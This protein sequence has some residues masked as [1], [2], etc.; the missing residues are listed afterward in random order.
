MQEMAQSIQSEA[1]SAFTINESMMNSMKIAHETMEISKGV[2]DN[3]SQICERFDEGWNKIERIRDQ[4][5][6]ISSSINTANKTVAE[7]QSSMQT[8]NNLLKGIKEIADQTNLL[9]LNATIESARAGEHGKG[10][11][12]VASEVRKLAEKSSTIVGDISQVTTG[13]FH[14]SQEAYE[15]VNEGKLATNEGQ[16]LIVNIFSYF[17]YLKDSFDNT[18]SEI[19]KSMGKIE[20]AS[21]IYLVTQNQIENMVSISQE[22][23]AATEEV[24][25]T[26]ENENTD[27]QQIINSINEIFNL[28]SQLK[29]MISCL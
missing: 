1:S 28:S 20:C 21:N 12:V 6:I 7:L 24:L 22:N 16:E 25:A 15:K 11:A 13:L 4:M 26:I 10:F 8:V 3:T 27:I 29:Q 18:H 9:A 2:I 23:A 19:S 17:K 5:G 14:K